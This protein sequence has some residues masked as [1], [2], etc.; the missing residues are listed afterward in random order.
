MNPP[1][2]PAPGWTL[3]IDVGG[4]KTAFGILRFPEAEIGRRLTLE[5]PEREATGLTFLERVAR[6]AGGLLQR[7]AS[8]GTPCAAVGVSVCELVDLSGQVTSAHRVRWPGLPVRERLGALAPAL[9]DADVRAAALAEA[10]WGAGRGDGQFL[11][12]NIGTGIS[13]CWV[14]GG[15]PHAGARGNALALASSPTSF[16]CP[17]CGKPGSYV[18]ED[19][20]GGAGLA[21]QYAARVGAATTSARD[22]LAAANAG[23]AQALAVID[24]ATRA[25]GHA[26]GLAINVLDPA[27]VV[28]GGGLGAASGIYWEGLVRET[29]AHVWSETT[30]DLPIKPAA[31]G[32]DSALIG[33]AARA[34]LEPMPRHGSPG[35][36]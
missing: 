5:T 7:A 3:G 13:T 8:D 36:P 28:V 1:Q 21:A 10:H 12:V 30:R 9:I 16:T 4:T 14:E 23:D 2:P 22:V 29:R 19:I 25:L 18:L 31:L 20:A 15:V 35:S 32:A 34:W 6:E 27:S 33:A 24:A 17:H 11:Y 26:L